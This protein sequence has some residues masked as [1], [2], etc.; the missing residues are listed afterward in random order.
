MKKCLNNNYARK[1][2]SD[3]TCSLPQDGDVNCVKPI[4]LKVRIYCNVS[5]KM[6]PTTITN[7]FCL[8]TVNT[9]L[10]I[11][12]IFLNSVVIISLWRS[13]QLRKKLCYF[14]IFVLSCFDLSVVIVTH[15][16][17][18]ASAIATMAFGVY[19]KLF[20]DLAEFTIIL[21]VEFAMLALLTLNVERFLALTY[22]FFHERMVTKERLI[23]FLALLQ[24][25]TLVPMTLTFQ[26][27]ILQRENVMIVFLTFLLS[28]FVYL[29]YRT[30]MIARSKRKNENVAP[31]NDLHELKKTR[32]NLRNMSTCSLAVLCFFA[33]SFPGIVYF[34][35]ALISETPLSHENDKVFMSWAETMG[36]ANSTIN[37]LILF[38]RNTVLRREGMKIIKNI[39]SRCCCV[40]MSRF[41][42]A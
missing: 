6:Q 29:N 28:L 19:D 23:Y 4:S 27:I 10:M 7:L 22:P 8:C 38:W 34:L 25:L 26:N 42:N 39:Q 13:S 11:A 18:M 35:Y 17:V 24:F 16:L 14:T 3:I 2:L 40:R 21:V 31:T 32:F 5:V 20:V 37:C 12:G 15:P 9:I 33:C 36:C 41:R 30:F 1:I